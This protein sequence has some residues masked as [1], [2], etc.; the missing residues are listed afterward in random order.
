[1]CEYIT[2][3]QKLERIVELEKILNEIQDID[4]L[5]E[6]ILTEAR[7]IV[8][9]DA[10]SIYV[11][12]GN[13]LRIRYSQN[14]TLRKRLQPGQKM[15][16]SSFSFPI[17]EKS[18]AGYAADKG[19]LVNIPNVY[20]IPKKMPF[21]FNNNSDLLSGYVTKSMLTLPLK[22]PMGR[23]LGVLQI[24]NAQDSQGNYIVF[25]KDAELFLE[26][27][28][29]DATQALER[30][31]LT[32][33]MVIKM[34][35]MAEFRDPK[36]T[37]N[38]VERVSNFAVEI[39]DRWAYE[40]NISEA[41]S[42][43]TRDTLKMAAMLHDVGKVGISDLILKK[44][45]KLTDDEYEIIKSHTYIGSLLFKNIDS[46]FDQMALD[47]C[48][49]HHER[50]D[51]KGYPGKIDLSL[52]K[53]STELLSL[54]GIAGLKGEEIPFPARI[55]ALADVFD[56]LSSK[57]AYKE[58]WNEEDVLAEI[59]AQSGKQFDPTIVDIFLKVLPAIREIQKQYPDN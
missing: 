19:E 35:Q 9:A 21:Q 44:P 27:F 8:N 4:V 10:G 58:P 23:I 14:D 17:N 24:I 31:Y 2:R 1:M 47:V 28:A 55:V 12:E 7:S 45:A 33:S 41:V 53:D 25:D 54:D 6:R 49:R 39:Y 5:L 51:G 37:G 48:L 56:A 52:L 20:S 3:E 57:R 13:S 36:E 32:R 11:V 22:T 59:K 30:A 34:I 15:I 46:E 40:N 16:F 43:K 29:S 26:N 38:H 42:H 18:I 50:Y